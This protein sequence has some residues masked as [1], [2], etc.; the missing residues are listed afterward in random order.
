MIFF[1]LRKGFNLILR[2][3]ISTKVNVL[4]LLKYHLAF[5]L[6]IFFPILHVRNRNWQKRKGV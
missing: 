6:P 2:F 3:I 1:L 4:F 5:F